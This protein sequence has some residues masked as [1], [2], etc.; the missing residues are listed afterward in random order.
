MQH[1]TPQNDDGPAADRRPT[2]RDVARESKLSVTQTSRALNGHAD[3]SEATRRRA[4][5]TAR[6]IGYSP[7]LE[8]RRLKNP[9]SKS[10]S[11]GLIL[12]TASQRFTD[13]F[14]GELLA[15]LVDEAAARGYEL[16]LS[17]P[18]PQEDPVTSYERAIRA[19]RVDGFV[20]LRTAVDDPR[21]DHLAA[22]RVPFVTYGRTAHA[23]AHPSVNDSAD[24]LRPAIDHLVALGHRHIACVAEPLTYTL[25]VDRHRSFVNALAA[26]D[27]TASPDHVVV[28]GYREE[29]GFAAADRLLGSGDP[30]TAVVTFNDL[31][32]IG[33]VNA[34]QA[35]GFP[36]PS[37]L[38]VVGFDDIY[39]ARHTSPPLTTMRH[40]ATT[41]G[42]SLVQ[43][44][45][46]A[47][48]EPATV[49][50]AFVTPELIV[51]GSTAVVR[52]EA[53]RR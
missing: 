52:S 21:I 50:A 23:G 48:D 40:R 46:R 6:R 15:A 43:Q 5:D 39:A 18:L 8:A 30:P 37:H 53:A 13:P 35:R 10:Y 2:L 1:S 49:E 32:A 9:A 22:S 34:A 16:Q 14:F 7:N 38:S 11:I 3:V 12:D 47:I 31:L 41:I 17:A 25:A 44:L 45:L 29:A 4:L 24:C 42:R 26:N 19:N 51:R 27:L 36:V 28:A 20:V 33:A